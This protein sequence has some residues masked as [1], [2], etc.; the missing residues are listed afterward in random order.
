MIM[1]GNK[2]KAN[3]VVVLYCPIALE[4][5]SNLKG[6]LFNWPMWVWRTPVLEPE[7]NEHDK[8]LMIK[9]GRKR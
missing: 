5:T 2:K 3:H 7:I 6:H 8:S 4:E 1:V 9:N